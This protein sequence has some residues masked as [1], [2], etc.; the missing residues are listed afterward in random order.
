MLT[1]K[2]VSAIAE[3][4]EEHDAYI[5]SDEIYSKMLYDGLEHHSPGCKDECRERTILVDGF[6]KA[7]SMTGWRLGYVVAPEELIH[8]M[9]LLLADAVSCTTSFVQKGGVEALKNG[10]DFVDY[11]MEKFAKRRISELHDR[12]GRSLFTTWNRFWKSG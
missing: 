12:R 5:L 7:Y 6:S 8:K 10:Q 9:D 3:M 11:I 1:K 2:D 4:A